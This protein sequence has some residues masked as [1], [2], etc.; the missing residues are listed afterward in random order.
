LQTVIDGYNLLFRE[1]DPGPGTSLQ[2]LREEFI[3]RV[4]AARFQGQRVIV[5]F[6]GKP[7]MPPSA[8]SSEGV[9]VLYSKTPRSADDL[10]VSL[11]ERAARGA[12]TVLT[13][14]RGLIRRVKSAGGRIGEPE[15]FFEVP[16]RRRAPDRKREKPP[17]PTGRELDDW[18]A[19]FEERSDEEAG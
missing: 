8:R 2:D 18:E 15:S 19:L 12:V 16:M 17:A 1:L 9:R 4:D 7:R 13:H 14:D 6:D 11:V 5:V 3:R 10:I